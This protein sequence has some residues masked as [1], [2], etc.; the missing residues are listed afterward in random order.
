MAKNV[1]L[2]ELTVEVLN[3]S[4]RFGLGLPKFVMQTL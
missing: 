4:E 3:Q 1:M 2:L